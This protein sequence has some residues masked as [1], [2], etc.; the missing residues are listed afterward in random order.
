MLSVAF[1]IVML[2]VFMVNLVMLNVVMVN[3]V[4]LNVFMPYVVMLSVKALKNKTFGGDK[5][6]SLVA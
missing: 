3:V 5:T 4:M 6:R 1:F 2:I